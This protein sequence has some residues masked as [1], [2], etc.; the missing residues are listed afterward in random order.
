MA[1]QFEAAITQAVNDGT[2]AGAAAVAVDKKG[3]FFGSLYLPEWK[4]ANH[5]AGDTIYA[6]AFG[7]RVYGDDSKPMALDSVAWLASCTKA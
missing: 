3:M 5:V 2:V 1:S 6:K 4:S 7:N